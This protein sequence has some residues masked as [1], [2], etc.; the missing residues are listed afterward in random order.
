MLLSLLTDRR[1]ETDSKSLKLATFVFTPPA[2]FPLQE[3]VAPWSPPVGEAVDFPDAGN[4][5]LPST[6]GC[7]ASARSG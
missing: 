2:A 6:A 3:G 5:I 4:C 7:T 1:G